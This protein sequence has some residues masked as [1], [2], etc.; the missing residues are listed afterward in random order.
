MRWI[1]RNVILSNY[2]QASQQKHM[3]KCD[4]ICD[5]NILQTEKNAQS[6]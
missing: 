1:Y 3:K 4:E 6:S 2:N 5:Y